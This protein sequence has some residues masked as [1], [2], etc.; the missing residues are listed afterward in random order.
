MVLKDV[1]QKVQK[2]GPDIDSMAQELGIGRGTLDAVL[3]MAVRE[4]YLEKA[5]ATPCCSGCPLGG[6]CKT[7]SSG[8][9][10]IRMYALTPDGEKYVKA[11]K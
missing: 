3:E 6:M 2:G 7:K 1:L 10:G 4:G 8:R 9:G 11:G 5:S